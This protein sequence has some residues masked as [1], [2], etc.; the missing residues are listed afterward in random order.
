MKQKARKHYSMKRKRLYAFVLI[1][2]LVLFFNGVSHGNAQEA[3]P[4]VETTAVATET[5]NIPTVTPTVFETGTATPIVEE[6]QVSS[7]V[8]QV[9]IKISRNAHVKGVQDRLDQQQGRVIEMEELEKIGVI[10]LEIPSYQ[11]EQK[12]QELQL[13][14]GV[15]YVEPNYSVQA[16]DLI[17]ND[18]GWSFQYGLT[19]IR[20]PQGWSLSTGSSSVTIA[21][22][23]SGVDLGHEDLAGRIVAGYDFVNNDS[24]PQDDFGHGTL[25]AGIAAASGNNGTGVAGVSWRARIMPLKVLN[26]SG[27]GSYANVAAGI[28]WAADHGAQVINLSL[29]GA[30]PSVTLQDAVLYAYNKGILL[31][32]ASGNN[33]GAQVLYPARYPEVMA[34]GATNFSNQPSSISN[35]GPEV[36]VAAPGENIYSLW[37]G[38]YFT[39]SGT[40]MSAPFVSG[41]AA[42]LF[43]FTSDAGVV[44][45]AIEST[46][47]DVGPVGWDLYSGAGLIQMDSAI[48]FM[49]PPASVTFTSVPLS[50]NSGA[51]ASSSNGFFLPAS[52][53]PS[54]T[55]TLL[56]TRPIASPTQTSTPLIVPHAAA[57]TFTATVT[58]T[59]ASRTLQWQSLFSPYSC[60]GLGLILTGLGLW[61]FAQRQT[62]L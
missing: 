25:V 22:L 21:I 41:L 57:P 53:T 10:L 58:P 45:N 50:D 56:P 37:P 49:L 16:M 9:L 31:V 55:V 48:A 13:V 12:I 32:A 8:T 39:Q 36:D 7:E 59:P 6:A 27:G 15:A 40:S 44:R 11:L 46:A 14:T 1:G 19:A 52:I 28:L 2:I 30:A 3:T 24:V 34:V 35:Y 51:G 42:I 60:G 5:Q 33:G 20:A 4:T 62:K 26:N 43:S 23:D 38:G 17:P 29:G 61:R 18:P 47:L 54:L